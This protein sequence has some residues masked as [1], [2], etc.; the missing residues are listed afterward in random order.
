MSRTAEDQIKAHYSY[1]QAIFPHAETE[2][3][4]AQADREFRDYDHATLS[5][6]HTAIG[7]LSSAGRY[8]DIERLSH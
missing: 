5:L 6:W 3:I 7:F 8:A 2:S 4:L 1:N